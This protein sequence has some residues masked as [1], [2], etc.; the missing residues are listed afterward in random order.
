MLAAMSR[1]AR[2]AVVLAVVLGLAAAAAAA[3]AA[4]QA[5]PAPPD[6]RA[7]AREFSFAAYRARVAV[8]AQQQAIEA[9]LTARLDELT[10]PR[11]LSALR[12]VPES[13][14]D[15]VAV[16]GLVLIAL[17]LLDGIRGP[18]AQLVA[19]LERV[20]TADPALRS[21]RAAWRAEAQFIGRIAPVPDVCGALETWRRAGFGGRGAPIDLAALGSPV[22]DTA[23]PKL[24]AAAARMRALGVSAGAARRFT[25]ANLLAGI[26][27]ADLDFIPG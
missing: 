23:E 5:P 2:R 18:L 1:P 10:K 16:V 6:E 3:P 26:G 20:P 25:G 14:R 4:A 21:G 13:R 27:D 19:E 8:K 9:A 7:A 11:C 24:A 22:A 15:T 17:P 12:A